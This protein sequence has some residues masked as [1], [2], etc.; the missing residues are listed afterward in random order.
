MTDIEIDLPA[1]PMFEGKP[2][3]ATRLKVTTMARSGLDIDAVLHMDDIIHVVVEARV[4]G[5]SHQVNEA[6]GSLVRHQTAKVITAQ[7]V[8]WDLDNPDDQGVLRG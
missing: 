4:S 6:T 5:V 8:P 2:V 1:I 3:E 7:L